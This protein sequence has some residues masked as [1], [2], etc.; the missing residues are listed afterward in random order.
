MIREY[1]LYQFLTLVLPQ[2]RE[3][4]KNRRKVTWGQWIYVCGDWGCCVVESWIP[5]YWGVCIFRRLILVIVILF[6]GILSLIIL[7]LGKFNNIRGI[8][9]AKIYSIFVEGFGELERNNE[10]IYI[11][12]FFLYITSQYLDHKR[13]G[14]HI[15]IKNF[16][17]LISVILTKK[18][19]QNERCIEKTTFFNH[20]ASR[21]CNFGHREWVEVTWCWK[22][23]L[24]KITLCGKNISFLIW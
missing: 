10:S 20:F 6:S 24:E 13:E 11:Y 23:G 19:I 22:F 15:S 12:I 16:K 9:W 2:W 8:M 18:I 4:T 5:I 1:I 3:Q 21:L 7:T 17:T 14:H